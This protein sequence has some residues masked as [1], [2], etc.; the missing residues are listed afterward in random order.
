MRV[1]CRLAGD[2]PQPEP[3]VG[4]EIGGLQSA[5]VEH[6]RLAFAVFDIQFAVV[7]AADRVGYDAAHA[8]VGNVELRKHA[9]HGDLPLAGLSI[10]HSM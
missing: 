8:V 2:G 9:F 6:Q 3:L 10:R 1:A 4:T 5:V 7:G